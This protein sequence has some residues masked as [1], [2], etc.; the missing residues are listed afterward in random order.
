MQTTTINPPSSIRASIPAHSSITDLE[1]ER[2]FTNW[3]E[4]LVKKVRIVKST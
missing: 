3:N 1:R 2:Y 4:G